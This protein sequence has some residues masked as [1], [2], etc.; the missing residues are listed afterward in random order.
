MA[1][2][3]KVASKS[4]CKVGDGKVAYLYGMELADSSTDVVT[5][6]TFL[7]TDECVQIFVGVTEYGAVIFSTENTKTTDVLKLT[8]HPI[9]DSG[10]SNDV[11]VSISASGFIAL[12]V[13]DTVTSDQ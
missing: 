12:G 11:S 3:I 9:H 5:P 10:T 4:V 8:A 13:G 2:V 1:N 6:A 7:Q